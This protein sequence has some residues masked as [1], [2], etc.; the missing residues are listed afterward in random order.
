MA[1]A[2]VAPLEREA[3]KEHRLGA[4]ALEEQGSLRAVRPQAWAASEKQQPCRSW[5]RESMAPNPAAEEQPVLRMRCAL[6]A[7]H[8]RFRRQCKAKR[9]TAGYRKRCIIGSGTFI[10]AAAVLMAP[11]EAHGTLELVMY[12]YL[13]PQTETHMQPSQPDTI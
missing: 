9:I 1:R 5:M 10:I 4:P 12:G 7:Q 13:F 8:S 2:C 11:A 3:T 6:S